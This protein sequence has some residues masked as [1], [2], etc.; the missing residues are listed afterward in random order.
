MRE[1]RAEGKCLMAKPPRRSGG[2]HE[3]PRRP[4]G[5]REPQS[6]PGGELEA[7]ARP[8]DGQEAPQRLYGLVVI[9][10]SAGGIE[11]LSTV[12][13][14]LTRD[15]AVPIVVAQHLDPR[16]PSH[17]DEILARR[18]VLRVR[19][20]TDREP[21]E[22]GVVFVV[23]ADRHVEITDGHLH[24]L[25][26]MSPR[27]KPSINLLLSSAAEAFSE[28]LIAVILTGTGSDGAAGARQVK[29]AGGTVVIENPETAAFPG[30][31]ASL[32]PTVV[33]LV[34]DLAQ[35]GPLLRSLLDGT[36][37]AALPGP[38]TADE[39][40]ARE[41]ALQDVLAQMREHSG[42]DFT[43]YKRPTLLRRLQ[44]RMI[45]TSV[46]SL[47]EY[48]RYLAKHPEEYQRLTSSFLIKVTEFFRDQ[49]L[50][51][52]LR[53]RMLPELIAHA[54]ENDNVLRLWSAGCATGEEAYSLA[55][56]VAE[57]L[58][59]ELERFQV[60]IFATDLDEE[61]VAFARRGVYP[62][63]ALAG[64]P[65]ALVERYFTKLDGSYE[66]TKAL[67][68]LII[69]GQHDLGQ[70]AP[71]PRIDLVLCRNV[72]IYFTKEL[73]ARA[74]QT[75][76]FSLRDGGYLALAKAET[77]RP[78]EALFAP[79]G[80][81]VKLYRRQGERVLGPFPHAE[82]LTALVPRRP[83][84]AR[85][86]GGRP[87]SDPNVPRAG[88]ARRLT[89]P[90][91]QRA[92]TT[93]EWLGD[94]V[95]SLPIGVVVVDRRY[96]IQAI[97]VSALRL[98]GIYTAAQGEDLIHLTQTVPSTALREVIDA[99]FQGRPQWRTQETPASDTEE[100]GRHD[101]AEAVV[102]LETVLGERRH[103]HIACYPY[104]SARD[105]VA[106]TGDATASPAAD[107]EALLLLIEDV[108]GTVTRQRAADDAVERRRGE[109]DVR[110]TRERGDQDRALDLEREENERLKAEVERIGVINRSL[111]E[112]NQNLAAALPE[113]RRVNEELEV[114][115]EEAEANAEEVKTLNE[116]LQAT[117][118]EVVTINEELEATVEELRTANDDM[119]ARGAELRDSAAALETQ[120]AA[121]EAARARLEAILLSL[122][123]AVMVVDRDGAVDLTN[124]AYAAMFGSGGAAFVAEDETGRPLGSEATPQRRAARGESFTME[125]TLTAGDGARRWFEASGQPIR[126]TGEERGGVVA[127]RDI[128]ERSMHR[129]EDEFV[130]LASH[131]LRTPLTPLSSYLE[132]L[133]RLFADQP[134]DARARIY[135]RH[136]LEQARRLRRLVE[137]LVDVRR[138]QNAKFA[139][140]MGR[141]RLEEVAERAVES[142]RMIGT[143]QS[144][145]LERQGGPIVVDGD[146][147]RLE[148]V[149]LNLLTNAITYAPRSDRIDVRVRRVAGEAELWVRDY[150][151]GIPAAELA[152]IFERFYQ[153]ARGDDRP[154]RRGLGLG[155]YIVHELVVA[156]GGRI[157]VESVEGARPGHGTTFTIYLPLAPREGT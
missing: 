109:R 12:L 32:S 78:L 1:R 94:V 49:D 21:L 67:R 74:L 141:V 111:L 91:A 51:D 120:R 132:L 137:D 44:R 118:E 7:P 90:A 58:G 93:G 142:A 39:T 127:I 14:S 148:Q 72:L 84:P 13:G 98:L 5:E 31:P 8:S 124:A 115:H 55:I 88:Q 147:A 112:A 92:R 99:A 110:Q 89:A 86:D 41:R 23:P 102:T 145:H 50:F 42:I 3:A 76:A 48:A 149:L 157:E 155:L 117:N 126:S 144:I 122:G 52:T 77:V 25:A 114:G 38:D 116:E 150:G 27:P 19:T 43:H 104:Q 70:R 128:T 105:R 62:G 47:P 130:G 22:P 135:I 71:F 10:S 30:M 138:L 134:E 63:A 101:S 29:A 28:R 17:L 108:S 16:H 87:A 96:D 40:D 37:A 83:Q 97:N 85:W 113:L 153:V 4:E 33:D 106:G 154:A 100:A 146:A 15:F 69:F 68:G 54:C 35:I 56:L 131:E 73:Q 152:H 80:G 123:D 140:E 6:R 57:A 66:V 125:F 119:R 11:A 129:L 61:A 59:E 34:A 26:D 156:H 121:S 81:A 45:A 82:D 143:G 46:G 53:E 75:F 65:E 139:L 103:L 24:L 2:D 151:A 36:V 64:L 107:V 79:V 133:D 136:A 95:L 9:G 20:V 60:L 18:S